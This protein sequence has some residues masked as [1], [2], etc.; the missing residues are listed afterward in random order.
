M[1]WVSTPRRSAR[2][3][4]SAMRLARSEGTPLARRMECTTACAE[5]G[6]MR[7]TVLAGTT[8]L[9]NGCYRSMR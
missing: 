9:G 2:T 7:V 6:V 4:A 5:A 1:P 3:R 8:I